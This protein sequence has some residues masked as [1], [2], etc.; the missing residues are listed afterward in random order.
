VRLPSTNIILKIQVVSHRIFCRLECSMLALMEMV[1]CLFNDAARY[2]DYLP[3]N[4]SMST[5]VGQCVEW[6]LAGVPKYWEKNY[7]SA[8]L[9]TRNPAGPDV[10][11]SFNGEKTARNCLNN[12][13][14]LKV[15]LLLLVSHWHFE[16]GMFSS[17]C[18][19]GIST[20]SNFLETFLSVTHRV[21][22]SMP[23]FSVHVMQIHNRFLGVLCENF[24]KL[25][26]PMHA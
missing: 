4:D 5:N 12:D 19:L 2:R 15:S 23:L 17:L 6:E 25:I 9:Y 20:T 8:T 7:P 16:L 11:M 3:S 18:L 10:N 13:I 21:F 24:T 26:S 1:S 14:A 22:A